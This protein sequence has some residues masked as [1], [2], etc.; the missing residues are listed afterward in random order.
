MTSQLLT[1]LLAVRELLSAPERWARRVL[2]RNKEGRPVS[3]FDKA[4]CRW[5]LQGAVRATVPAE[6]RT[7]VIGALAAAINNNVGS[8]GENEDSVTA[9]NDDAEHH[10][11]VLA[12]IDKAIETERA[13]A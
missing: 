6:R 9:F 12:L 4:A 5:C 1:D 8:L 2:A 10:A 11:E 3:A 13:A 7:C